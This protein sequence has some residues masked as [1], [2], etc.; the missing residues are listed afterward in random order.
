MR[1]ILR[2]SGLPFT[3]GIECIFR[4]R[5]KSTPYKTIQKRGRIGLLIAT[6]K[7]LIFG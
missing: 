2:F 6:E 5:P 7:V 3:Y 1:H 4:T